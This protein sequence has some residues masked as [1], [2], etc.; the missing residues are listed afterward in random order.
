MKSDELGVW[1][2]D[3]PIYSKYQDSGRHA[4]QGF[5]WVA[6]MC[7]QQVRGGAGVVQFL[8]LP[9]VGCSHP[10]GRSGK[11]SKGEDKK[12]VEREGLFLLES[13]CHVF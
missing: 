4:A 8:R 9:G 6:C 7:Y 12:E 10:V 13:A 1:R 2:P 11:Q 3:Q 5:S